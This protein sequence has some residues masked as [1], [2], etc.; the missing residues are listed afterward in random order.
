MTTFVMAKRFKFRL[1]GLHKFRRYKTN[2]AKLAF[3]EIA[4]LRN[5]KQ[6]EIAQQRDYLAS[7]MVGKSSVKAAELQMHLA[8][9]SSVRDRIAT[10][11]KELRNLFEIESLRR[12]ELTHT[13]RDEKVMDNLHDKKLAE[14]SHALLR[15]EQ[16]MM[17]EIALRTE[18]TL[19]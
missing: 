19:V 9:I 8:H 12:K 18:Q 7:L 16:I 10:L 2:E 5:A 15:E 11:E 13:M 17:D 4:Q 14:H 3:G 1:D 6:Q